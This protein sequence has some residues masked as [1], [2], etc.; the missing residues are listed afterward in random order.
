[1]AV[2]E[3]DR[4][5]VDEAKEAFGGLVVTSGYPSGFFNLLSN[6]RLGSAGRNGL[7]KQTLSS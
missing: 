1:M 7:V 6:V 3:V 5:D 4:C 2:P